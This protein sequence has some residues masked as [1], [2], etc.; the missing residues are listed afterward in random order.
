M[1]YVPDYAAAVNALGTSEVLVVGDSKMC[2][3][4]TRGHIVAGQSCYLCAYRP[5][6]A[7]EEL[8]TWREQALARVAT[9]HCLE[10]LDPKTGE[11]LA[12]VM[13]DE[14]EREHRWTHP[15]TQKAHTW[16]ERVLVVRSSAYQAGLRRRRE[17]ALARLTDDLVTLWHSSGRGCKSY[18][19]CE[20]LERT[21]A[22]RITRAG[23]IGVV[24]TALSEETLSYFFSRCIVSAVCVHLSACQALMARLGWQ[25]YVTNTTMAHYSATALVAS[26]HQQALEERGFS[27]LTSYIYDYFRENNVDTMTG[28]TYDKKEISKYF[29]NITKI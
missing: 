15:V 10:K 1:L 20:E 28:A 5:P 22:E 25:V 27:C 21:V 12:E 11:V 14:W 3:L 13:I 7:S 4:A 6:T 19:S 2:A 23:L 29:K 18:R 24:Q 17:R 8:A 16:T 9:W 26:Y